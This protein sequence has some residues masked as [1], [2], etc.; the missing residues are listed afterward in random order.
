MRRGVEGEM[1]DPMSERPEEA[2]NESARPPHAGPVSY[3]QLWHIL[4]FSILA[5]SAG[6][7]LTR[8]IPAL[9][10]E[11]LPIMAV[12][13]A[14]AAFALMLNRIVVR[15]P[16][17]PPAEAQ[18]LIGAGLRALL[19]SAGPSV[20]AID[21]SGQLIYCNPAVERLLGYHAAE[22]VNLAGL[23]E[24]EIVGS[25][26]TDRLLAEMKKLCNIYKAPEAKAAERLASYFEC[27]RTLP[28]SMVPSFDTQVRRKNGEIF[29]ITLHIS[30]LR[31][32]AGELGGLVAVAVDQSAVL[33]REQAQ[34][35][36]QE[37]YRDLFENSSE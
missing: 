24:M 8:L 18:D 15:S 3:S 9:R 30:A 14:T 1:A 11:S 31:D 6:A 13:I 12:G 23:A 4:P 25:G 29:P 37:R 19:D 5:F 27:V 35:E 36:S 2:G 21:L 16:A 26:K 7:A 20:V 17:A 33:H 32:S 28:P 10:W 34:R 22:L